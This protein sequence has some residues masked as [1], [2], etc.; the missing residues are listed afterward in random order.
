M[1][2]NDQMRRLTSAVAGIVVMLVG[3]FLAVSLSFGGPGE[4]LASL[5]RESWRAHPQPSKVSKTFHPPEVR[6]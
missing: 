6:Q 1:G 3:L 5:Y 4:F 2:T